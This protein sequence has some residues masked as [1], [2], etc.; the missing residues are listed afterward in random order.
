MKKIDET[1]PLRLCRR[2]HD[3]HIDSLSN[4]L[5]SSLISNTIHPRLPLNAEIGLKILL[6]LHLPFHTYYYNGKPE[7]K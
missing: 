1:F 6:F 4:L 7:Q 3:F 2:G 5:L